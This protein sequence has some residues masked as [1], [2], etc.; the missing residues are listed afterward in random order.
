MNSFLLEHI[1][2]YKEELTGYTF[3]HHSE[4]NIDFLKNNKGGTIKFINGH[5]ELKGGGIFLKLLGTEKNKLTQL[6]LLM[7]IPNK[8]YQ[9][10]YSKNYIFYSKSLENGKIV[11]VNNKSDQ[12]RK[13]MQA[14]LKGLF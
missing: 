3:I 7:K 4:D 11:D 10:S 13:M 9:L 6:K 2:K 8:L 5:G 1:E 14:L 12:T